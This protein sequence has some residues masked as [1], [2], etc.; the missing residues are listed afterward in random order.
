M[1]AAAEFNALYN[2]LE[3]HLRRALGVDRPWDFMNLVNEAVRRGLVQRSQVADIHDCKALRNLLVHTPRYPHEALAEPTQY[4]LK[5]FR[6]IVEAIVHPDRLTPAFQRDL[7]LFAPAQPL[8]QA[9]RYMDEKDYSQVVVRGGPKPAD[10]GRLALL[11]VDGVAT[12]LARA[13]A[14]TVDVDGATVADVLACEAEGTFRCLGRHATVHDARAAFEQARKR[15]QPRLYAVIITEN[16][17]EREQPL[18]LVTPWD[19]IENDGD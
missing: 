2:E 17:D 12:W 8:A 16:G 18:G 6:Q 7:R 11:T 5:R 4:G 19:L 1:D 3:S 15:P 10:A 14:A 9:L 13:V